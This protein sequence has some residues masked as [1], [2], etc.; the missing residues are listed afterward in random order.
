MKWDD[1]YPPFPN[2]TPGSTGALVRI[3]REMIRQ[4]RSDIYDIFIP[5]LSERS[6]GSWVGLLQVLGYLAT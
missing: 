6:I 2:R 3:A 5:S 4:G 1:I